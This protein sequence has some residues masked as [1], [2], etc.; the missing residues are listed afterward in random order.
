MDALYPGAHNQATVLLDFLQ[1]AVPDSCCATTGHMP[2]HQDGGKCTIDALTPD[3]RRMRA[4]GR[5]T[6]N[7][8]TFTIDATGGVASVVVAAA[9]PF[10]PQPTYGTPRVVRH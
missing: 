2:A 3:I 8:F 7:A 4:R 1:G 10:D 9:V 5:I 6:M